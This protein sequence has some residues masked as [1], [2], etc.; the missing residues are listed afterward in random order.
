MRWMNSLCIC[1]MYEQSKEMKR[2]MEEIMSY[3]TL[4]QHCISATSMVSI[5]NILQ[6]IAAYVVVTWLG[7]SKFNL[8]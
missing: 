3:F 6:C 7:S 8:K 5:E 1:T 4:L 2:V